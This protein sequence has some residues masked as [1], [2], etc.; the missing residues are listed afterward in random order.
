MS[1][2]PMYGVSSL[3]E[4]RR[5]GERA[6]HQ[7]RKREQERVMEVFELSV[8]LA[9]YAERY[10]VALS[11]LAP[12]Y[13]G[14]SSQC[15]ILGFSAFSKSRGLFDFSRHLVRAFT[16]R[17]HSIREPCTRSHAPVDG[18][19]GSGAVLLSYRHSFAVIECYIPCAA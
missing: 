10:L 12:S 1:R 13:S 7:E 17:Y 4:R 3:R 16:F 14:D 2:M 9:R 8:P 5:E 6:R 18:R 19:M 11:T 15:V